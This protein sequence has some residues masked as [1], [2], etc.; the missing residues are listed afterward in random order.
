MKLRRDPDGIGVGVDVKRLVHSRVWRGDGRRHNGLP[1]RSDGEGT[2]YGAAG[3]E[4]RAATET[5]V[6]LLTD[7]ASM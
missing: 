3:Y 5:H 4:E 6:L 2:G 7:R 1:P